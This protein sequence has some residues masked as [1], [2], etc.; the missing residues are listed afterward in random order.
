MKIIL[1]IIRQIFTG[2][3]YKNNIIGFIFSVLSFVII[4]RL[5][6]LQVINGQYYEDNYV[7]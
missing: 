4:V 6:N 3:N 2:E 1:Y 5:F 7:Q